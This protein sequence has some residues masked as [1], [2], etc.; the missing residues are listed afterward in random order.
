M[1]VDDWCAAQCVVMFAMHMLVYS[2][3]SMYASLTQVCAC[4]VL[5][6]QVCCTYYNNC[7]QVPLLGANM[8]RCG[9][10]GSAPSECYQLCES[11]D[12]DVYVCTLLYIHNYQQRQR[13]CRNCA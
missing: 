8:G 10:S 12:F 5:L 7:M 13:M 11:I 4:R 6:L 2:T 1:L 9:S 3:S